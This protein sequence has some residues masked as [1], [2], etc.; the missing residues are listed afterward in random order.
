[1]KPTRS[2]DKARSFLCKGL[3]R[4][5]RQG[6]LDKM[7]EE[8]KFRRIMKQVVSV[9]GRHAVHSEVNGAGD[10]RGSIFEGA[11]CPT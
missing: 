9:G 8:C 1:M 2:E 7:P 10:V 5:G 3:P 4:P 11:A 6:L